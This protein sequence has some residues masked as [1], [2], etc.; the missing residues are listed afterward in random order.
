MKK[1]SSARLAAVF[2]GCFLGAGFVSGQEIWQYFGSF[3]KVG[4]LGFIVS[5]L[6]MFLFGALILQLVRLTSV[7]E[8]DRLVF[9]WEV[10]AA[11]AAVGILE[12]VFMF[13][14]VS[15][16]AAGVGALGSQLFGIPAWLGSLVFLS[17]VT[18]TAMAGL[19]G[20][21]SV[22]SVAV[23]ILAVSTLAFGVI[24]LFHGEKPV[25]SESAANSLLGNW[26]VSA[27]NYAGYN[28]F[29]TI[30]IL[31]PFGSRL[32]SPGK[33]R[34]GLAFGSGVLFVIAGS[35]LLSIPSWEG[36][37]EA[38]LPMLYA[39][40]QL[41]PAAA[42]G[43]GFLMLAGMFGTSLSNLVG[44]VRFLE[45]KSL[46]IKKRRRPATAVFGIGAFAAS[47]CGFGGLIGVL[48]PLF[49]YASAVFLALLAVHYLMVQVKRRRSSAG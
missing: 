47:L 5:D 30:A 31:A 21:V 25:L 42:Y 12:T 49:G 34:L 33:T 40:E 8:M 22:F 28:I 38:E 39:A 3:G 41:H 18:L 10:P 46:R 11:R 36:A 35:I 43:Y 32:P 1:L 37:A 4:W 2:A 24:A 44:I 29:S 23:P 48:Y 7:H 45:D 20:I 15:I 14:I 27:L 26:F 13:G 19:E 17:A 9:P 16:M 6:V